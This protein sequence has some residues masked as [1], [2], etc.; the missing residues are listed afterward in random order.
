VV[1]ETPE[2]L[3][4]SEA[5]I[6]NEI[7][8]K[9][10]IYGVI[11]GDREWESV[12]FDTDE[13]MILPDVDAVNEG[14]ILNWLVIF[15]DLDLRS[16][17]DLRGRHLEMLRRVRDVVGEVFP[18]TNCMTYFHC[19]PSVWQLHLHVSAPCDT[20]RT[21]NDMQK[22]LFLDDVISN[23]EI[24]H[25]YY[26]KVTMTYILPTTHELIRIYS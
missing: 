16:V 26:G 3:G 20:L 7:Q 15:K 25:E 19:P 8:K 18:S 13:F 12:K 14:P 23:L 2:L 11:S 4:R 6:Q 17:R 24:D 1:H 10:W 21:T 9:Q 5:F 22:V